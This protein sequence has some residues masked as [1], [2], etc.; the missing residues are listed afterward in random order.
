MAE[1][2]RREVTTTDIQAFR[3]YA[4][5]KA[6]ETGVVDPDIAEGLFEQ[7]SGFNPYA[8]SPRGA[9][10]IGQL[11][12]DTAKKHGLKPEDRL[13]PF[14]NIDASI[15]ELVDIHNQ[16]PDLKWIDKITAYNAGVYG[17]KLF[18]DGKY[19]ELLE[20]FE[21]PEAKKARLDEI[22]NFS[23]KVESKIVGF[24][25]SRGQRMEQEGAQQ[26]VNPVVG[27]TPPADMVTPSPTPEATPGPQGMASYV[28]PPAKA[29]LENVVQP[30][31]ESFLQFPTDVTQNVIAGTQRAGQLV[32]SALGVPGAVGPPDSELVPFKTIDP[33]GAFNFGS[34]FFPGSPSRFGPWASRTY[35]AARG[36]G[37]SALNIANET[38]KQRAIEAGLDYDKLGP[39]ARMDLMMDEVDTTDELADLIGE[40]AGSLALSG[41]VGGL[42]GGK[43]ADRKLK[44]EEMDAAYKYN[45]V[46]RSNEAAVENAQLATAAERFK[47]DESNAKLRE[48]NWMYNS[49]QAAAEQADLERSDAF[50]RRMGPLIQ[51][52]AAVED[53]FSALPKLPED[54]VEL[55]EWFFNQQARDFVAKEV[56][57]PVTDPSKPF[58]EKLV[59]SR[60]QPSAMGARTLD[61]NSLENINNVLGEI[62]QMARKSGILD[63]E[64]GK[65]GRPLGAP[66]PEI[67]KQMAEY[68]KVANNK[69][70]PAAARAQAAAEVAKLEQSIEPPTLA[71]FIDR[72]HAIDATR[73]NKELVR[74]T[75]DGRRVA[76][77]LEEVSGE[78]RAPGGVAESAMLPDEVEAWTTGNALSRTYNEQLRSHDFVMEHFQDVKPGANSMRNALAKD[79]KLMIQRFGEERYEHLY[80]TAVGLDTL[81]AALPTPPKKTFTG[82]KNVEEQ[83][84]GPQVV[85]NTKQLPD[86]NAMLREAPVN[87]TTASIA[88]SSAMLANMAV[89]GAGLTAG[90]NVAQSF[91]KNAIHY[92]EL[93][94]PDSTMPSPEFVSNTMGLTGAA[95]GF[96]LTSKS[97]GKAFSVMMENLDRPEGREYRQAAAR[98]LAAG[99]IHR[100]FAGETKGRGPLQPDPEPE[101]APATPTPQASPIP[102]LS[103]RRTDGPIPAPPGSGGPTAMPPGVQALR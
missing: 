67:E 24:K 18:R 99:V 31:A 46:L 92:L 17:Y 26:T 66:S 8:V 33:M 50:A 70:M 25:Q 58:F 98:L 20:G 57:L 80:N 102:P 76:D 90:Y 103:S 52:K 19:D 88:K 79:K 35:Q 71:E 40:N 61:P 82:Y 29:V 41:G 94:P 95:L 75:T 10:G 72:L 21:T 28:V 96:L 37:E 59:G 14:K 74:K 87:E 38:A 11:T 23:S 45:D 68:G 86:V 43:V 16:L 51:Q 1:E 6:E 60:R 47:I 91:T 77:F 13:K 73:R 64:F 22:T 42:L 89:R 5:A 44:P 100:S 54:A 4:R 49:A 63:S 2:T 93:L 36:V 27:E 83:A 32:D 15:A 55:E 62:S 56:G 97:A 53:R 3:D 84:Y 9:T 65:L 7:E 48:D 85:P 69:K 30:M 101:P 34:A 78:L 12:R 39:V 81:R